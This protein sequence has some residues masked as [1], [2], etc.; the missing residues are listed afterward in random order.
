MNRRELL[1]ALSAISLSP[2]IINGRKACAHGTTINPARKP[3]QQVRLVI[4]DDHQGIHDGLRWLLEAKTDHK[5]IGDAFDGAEAVKLVHQ[6][7]PDILILNRA[8][9]KHNGWYALRELNT[10]PPHVRVILFTA[11]IEKREIVEA[12]ELGAGGSCS[13]PTRSMYC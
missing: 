1:K 2:L 5:I 12:L 6:L 9:P 8:M 4:A 10:N 11:A 3:Q 7:K 13:S